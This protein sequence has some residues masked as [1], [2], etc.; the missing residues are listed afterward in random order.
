MFEFF[1]ILSLQSSQLRFLSS[2]CYTTD[3]TRLT[4]SPYSRA[5]LRHRRKACP[6][7]TGSLRTSILS[8]D[9][10]PAVNMHGIMSASSSRKAKALPLLLMAWRG[11]FGLVATRKFDGSQQSKLPLGQDIPSSSQSGGKINSYT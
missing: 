11:R 1:Q 9:P 6:L 2:K 5:C 7:F 4:S 3:G 8:C 10:L